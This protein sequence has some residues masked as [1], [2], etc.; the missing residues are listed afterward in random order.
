MYV[1]QAL[2]ALV[3]LHQQR[4][5]LVPFVGD[6]GRLHLVERR[7]VPG[8]LGGDIG[9]VKTP[10]L[11]AVSVLRIQDVLVV[12]LP[13]EGVNTA[14]GIVGDRSVVVLAQGTDPDVQHAI[15]RGQIPQLRAV[16]RDDGFG[17]LRIAE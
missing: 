3:D 12:V 14:I 9:L 13:A 11:V 2:V 6:D 7:Q 1:E 10:V 5:R 16:G 4:L 8:L 17:A 15:H